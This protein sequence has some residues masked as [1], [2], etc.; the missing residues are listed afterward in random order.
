MTDKE[1]L[2]AYDL[3]CNTLYTSLKD[4]IADKDPI[5]EDPESEA[6]YKFG[7]ECALD[8]FISNAEIA[9]IEFEK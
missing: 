1:K 2:A 6:M 4:R 3:F 9:D 7:L 5:Y 8:M